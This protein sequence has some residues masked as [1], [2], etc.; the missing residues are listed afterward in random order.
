MRGSLNDPR[1]ADTG[2]LLLRILV[3]GFML[4]HGTD[5]IIH[6]PLEIQ[7]DLPA[8]G[9]PGALGYGVYIGE[10]LAPVLILLGAWTRLAALVYAG[11]IAFAT[12]L[13]HGGDFLHLSP[14]GA[15]AAKL[16]VFYIVTPVLVMLLGPGRYAVHPE[17]GQ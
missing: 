12:V 17:R 13:V 2:K 14:K 15:W 8:H 6:G 7:E 1:L 3:A 11:S 5:S 16:W 4:F 10:V 9:L